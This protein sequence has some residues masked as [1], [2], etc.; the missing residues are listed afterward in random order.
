MIV[1]VLLLLTSLGTFLE[2]EIVENVLTNNHNTHSH[3]DS[4]DL[5]GIQQNENW[6]VIIIEFDGIPT[7]SYTH[8]TLPT[9]P[10]V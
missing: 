10:Y 3:E 7:V 5:L 4:N 9:T 1:A 8:L 2:P 6:L